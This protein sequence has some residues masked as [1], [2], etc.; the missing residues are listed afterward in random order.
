[1]ADASAGAGSSGPLLER[2]TLRPARRSRGR[3][4]TPIALVTRRAARAALTSASSSARALAGTC[5]SRTNRTVRPVC[6]RPC[7][8]MLTTRTIGPILRPRP[9]VN[10]TLAFPWWW[11]SRP[12]GRRRTGT[13]GT[14][15]GT[16][17]T[18]RAGTPHPQRPNDGTI[19]PAPPTPAPAPTADARRRRGRHGSRAQPGACRPPDCTGRATARCTA[20]DRHRC[21]PDPTARPDGSAARTG[22]TPPGQHPHHA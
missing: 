1:M 4:S 5:D 6:S 13:A 21:G 8:S 19:S 2:R 17:H 12:A 11:S 15:P 20:S 16:T 3:A 10:T 18:G 22:H 7:H 14:Q 9:E